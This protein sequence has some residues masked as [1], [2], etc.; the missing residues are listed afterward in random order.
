MTTRR[1]FIGGAAAGAATLPGS[2]ANL[3]GKCLFLA[4]E[5]P[6]KKALSFSVVPQVCFGL[7]GKPITKTFSP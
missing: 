2:M 5:P 6:E 1:A 3:P 7:E 4:K